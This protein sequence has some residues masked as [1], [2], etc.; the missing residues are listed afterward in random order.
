MSSSAGIESGKKCQPWPEHRTWP[1]CWSCT[2]GWPPRNVLSALCCFAWRQPTSFGKEDHRRISRD[3][4]VCRGPW[5]RYPWGSWG[6]LW[7]EC[8]DQGCIDRAI[9]GEWLYRY[10]TREIV[11]EKG[12]QTYCRS[13]HFQICDVI[14]NEVPLKLGQKHVLA[15]PREFD[16]V[17]EDAEWVLAPK[18]MI[19]E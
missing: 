2:P 11:R 5:A 8:W 19:L 9:C 3:L 1:W 7:S 18:G 15:N 10:V 4:R 13:W 16:K 6:C 17:L 12:R 14:K